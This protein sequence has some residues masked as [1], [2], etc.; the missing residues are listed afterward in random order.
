[1]LSEHCAGIALGYSPDSPGSFISSILKDLPHSPLC[2]RCPCVMF[3]QHCRAISHTPGIRATE[4]LLDLLNFSQLHRNQY[5]FTVTV[6][7]SWYYIFLLLF[8]F[9]YSHLC[10]FFFMSD[11]WRA[12]NA[13]NSDQLRLM[14]PAFNFNT[15]SSVLL[16]T[17]EA[18]SSD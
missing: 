7:H 8:Y 15:F 13:T 6:I 14:W 9:L 4:D 10:T 11:E 18:L 17:A 1:M 2:H 5:V 12:W 16:F 3:Q